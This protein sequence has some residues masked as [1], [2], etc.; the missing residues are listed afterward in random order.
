MPAE[1]EH[2]RVVISKNSLA[3]TGEWGGRPLPHLIIV[4][5]RDPGPVSPCPRPGPPGSRGS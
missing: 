1:F 4:I 5:H 3:A 2:G